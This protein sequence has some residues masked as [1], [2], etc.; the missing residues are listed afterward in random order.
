MGW[1]LKAI[2]LTGT[3]I[4][5]EHTESW[6]LAGMFPP[7]CRILYE[8]ASRVAS[9]IEE[10]FLQPG[11]VVATLHETGQQWDWPNGWAPLQ[12]VTIIGLR[13]YGYDDLLDKVISRLAANE[14][15]YAN[16]N[17][18]VEKY[19]VV[20]PGSLSGGGEYKLQDGFGWT[21][22]V[23]MALRH[24]YDLKI[25]EKIPAIAGICLSG[26]RGKIRCQVT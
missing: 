15:L 3:L 19:N 1:N 5:K 25:T 18:F 12:W 6:S 4:K 21:N 13:R 9:V 26:G 22:G 10:K 11:G 14:A 8:Q 16:K 23:F 24:D 20:D 2:I 17:K 7:L